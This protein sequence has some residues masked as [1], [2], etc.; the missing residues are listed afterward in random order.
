[1][2]SFVVLTSQNTGWQFT[3]GPFASDA[4]ANQWIADLPAAG[5]AAGDLAAAEKDGA[6]PVTDWVA[7]LNDQ[8]GT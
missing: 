2:S 3:V 6:L 1:V 4:A 8:A 5:A 7:A